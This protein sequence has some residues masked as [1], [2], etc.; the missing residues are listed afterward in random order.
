MTEIGDRP[1]LTARQRALLADY[2]E[3]SLTVDQVVE[4]HGSTHS[5]LYW[6]IRKSREPS[7]RSKTKPARKA[8]PPR[9][10]ARRQIAPSR[11]PLPG[12]AAPERIADSSVTERLE[13]LLLARIADLEDRPVPRRLSDPERLARALAS[14]VRTLAALRRLEAANPAGREVRNAPRAGGQ[15]SD[16]PDRPVRSL[17]ELRDELGRH[18]ERI[19]LEERARRGLEPDGAEQ[20]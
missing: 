19:R 14:H 20:G 5:A 3:G 12:K 16:E 15:E 11:P 18:L 7:R 4:R 6:A 10:A 8:K 17:A 9:R 13:R 2:R 1:A